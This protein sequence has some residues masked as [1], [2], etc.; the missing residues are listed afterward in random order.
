[1]TPKGKITKAAVLLLALS[2]SAGM[3]RAGTTG[4]IT[5]RV[6]D[7]D[8]REALVGVNITVVGTTMGAA[9][10]IEGR[11]TILNVAPDT[12]TLRGSLV[13]YGTMVVNGVKVE[14]DQT[15]TINFAIAQ[16]TLNLGEVVVAAERRLVKRDVSTSVAS[17]S[18]EEVRALPISDVTAVASLQAGVE[19]GL[20][21][22]GGGA[23]QSLLLMDGATLRD[24]RNNQPVLGI[25]LSAIKE[26]SIERGGFEAE[27]GNVRS[28]IVNVVTKEGGANNYFIT[29]TGR[30]QPYAKKYDG[31]SPYDP[32]SMWL[33]PYMDPAVAFTGTASGGWDQYMQ[34]Q[35]PTFEGWNAI[36]KDLMS[37]ADPADDLTPAAAQRLFEW[38]HRKRP[39]TNSPDYNLDLG[40]GG[41]V[42]FI[43]DQLGNMRFFASYRN[44]R[45]MLLIPLSRPDYREEFGSLR[46]TSNIGSGMKLDVTGTMGKT[47]AN[48]V[49]FDEQLNSTDYLRSPY[50]ITA[51]ISQLGYGDSRVFLDSF[52]SLA[53][54]TNYSVAAQFNH[55]LNSKA[56]YDVRV[57]YITRS[58]ETGPGR[59]RDTSKVYELFPGYFVD[60]AP[61]GYSSAL[62]PVGLG[63][64]GGGMLMGGHTSTTRDSTTISALTIKGDFTAQLD[65]HN[66]IKAGAEFAYNDL[67]VNYGSLK[68]ALVDGN[69]FVK[70]HRFPIRLA[71]YIQDKLEF[72]GFIANL[73]VRA[74]YSS[75]RTDWPDV[76]P[77]NANFYAPSGG[78]IAPYP[79]KESKGQVIFSPRLGISHPITE[80]SKLYFNYG[81]F[82]QLSTYEEL[83]RES[84]NINKAVQ[85]I[86][87]PNLPMAKTV[88]YELGY[89]HSLSEEYLFQL[90]AFYRD[91]SNQGSFQQYISSGTSGVIYNQLT[92]NGYQDI[93]GFEVTVRK[94]SGRWWNG[95]ANFTYPVTSGGHFG[96]I[97]AYQNPAKQSADD[98]ITTNQYQS[99][100]LP[101]PYA[102]L[103]LG[104]F[105]PDDISE[106]PS[107]RLLLAGW[108][109]SLLGDWRGGNYVTWN[110]DNLVLTAP[111]LKAVDW[112][113]L[114]LR[115]SKSI[116]LGPVKLQLF[117]DMTNV[118]DANRLN[119]N[120]FYDYNDFQAYFKSLHL[121]ASSVYAG[122]NYIVGDDKAGEYRKIGV[123]YQPIVPID[124]VTG[125]TGAN[126][127]AIYYEKSTG[128]YMTYLNSQWQPVDPGRL[129]QVLKDKAY[130]DMPNE[131]SFWFLNPRNIFFGITTTIDL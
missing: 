42:P 73:G 129:D 111:N 81:H 17:V 24:P 51:N 14:I 1:M 104:L 48:A 59:E 108:N 126:A 38:Q 68:P 49:N 109:I 61:F 117:V 123:P 92:D 80:N 105:T 110:P 130:I 116:P 107:G 29:M 124:N 39:D 99:T 114:N 128:R 22:R 96:S 60:E 58:Y 98:I 119:L 9:T 45:E 70:W 46:L 37:N 87:D 12:Y 82:R 113:N 64:D 65:A 26:V 43:G 8:S 54:V 63:G 78:V 52:Y 120:S 83:F 57:E 84:R 36:S 106:S 79:T 44:V 13:G 5:G 21:I 121:P 20:V 102:R 131:S 77:Y 15:T 125:F 32:N 101:S 100:P 62:T 2:L 91:I 16:Q 127:T 27:Y 75:L 50:Q 71:G 40:A 76:D 10:D 34:A 94:I 118:F 41:P 7:K 25:A 18:N 67:N 53:E 85:N 90:S 93:R 30:Y 88:A 28:G 33:R 4:K 72:E 6:T 122:T 95:F 86:G 3:V 103:S 66:Q 74:D 97:H 69:I 23:D 19:G 31:I 47:F 115:I 112:Y 55:L 89:D 56:Y 11:Y 35:Y